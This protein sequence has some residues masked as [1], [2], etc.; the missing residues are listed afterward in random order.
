MNNGRPSRTA[1]KVALNILALGE[2][3]EMSGVL[4]FGIV[5][6]TAALLIASGATSEKVVHWSRSPWMVRLYECFDWLMPG[7]FEAFA[8][9][10]A[11]CEQQVR[12]SIATGVKQVLVLGAGYDTMGWRL[13]PQ[14][15]NVNFFEI[16]HPATS[17]LKTRGIAQMGRRPN[18]HIIA[19]DLSMRRLV[20]ILAEHEIWDL[21]AQTIMI[22]EGLLPYLS[23]EAAHDL[24]KQCAA[25]TYEGRIAFTYI[26]SCQNGL[27]DAGPWSNLILWLL[28]KSGEPWLWSIQPEQLSPF[29][30][31]SGWKNVPGLVVESAKSGLERYAVAEKQI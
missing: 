6:A 3:P 8:H 20:D 27:P 21:N 23:P 22:A 25:I 31:V 19:E 13:A 12:M 2:K 4:P 11:F 10:K 16:D 14:F 9:R 15:P 18:L 29:L 26:P 5:D 28:K 30:E 17:N 7:Q 1:Y 24:F